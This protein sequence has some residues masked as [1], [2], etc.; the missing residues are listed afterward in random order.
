MA[1]IGCKTSIR[2]D[3]I[4]IVKNFTIK[5]PEQSGIEEAPQQP[6]LKRK[7]NDDDDAGDLMD[8]SGKFIDDLVSKRS[9]EGNKPKKQ[10]KTN[11]HDPMLQLQQQQVHAIKEAD[12]KNRKFMKDLMDQ[13]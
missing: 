6:S 2:K 10:K 13:Q 3:E 4:P 5:V 7:H 1:E 9:E 12:E 8:S 11:F